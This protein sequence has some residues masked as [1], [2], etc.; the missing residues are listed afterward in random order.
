[1]RYAI[2]SDIHGNLEALQTV[3]NYI[4]SVNVERIVCLGDVVGYGPNPNECVDLVRRRCLHTVMGNHDSAALDLAETVHMNKYARE[5]AVWTHQRLNP[6]SQTF[7]QELPLTSSITNATLVHA[8]PHEPEQWHYILSHEDARRAARF[9]DT[10]VC[11][12]GHSHCPAVFNVN[13]KSDAWPKKQIIN[14]GSVGQPRD[15]NPKLSFGI[16]DT[17]TLAYEHI[18]LPYPVEITARKILDAGL[19]AALAERLFYGV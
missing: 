11:F 17:A 3:L 15:R 10:P 6:A 8:S 18:R 14:V 16:F 1:M 4:E 2:I 9:F 19:P 7:L 5:A 13:S 12:V